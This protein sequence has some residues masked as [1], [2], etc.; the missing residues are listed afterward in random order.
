MK[1]IVILI[2]YIN[3]VSCSLS[4]KINV[5]FSIKNNSSKTISEIN[6]QT[7]FDSIQIKELK[8][9]ESFRK[10]ILYCDLSDINQ[11]ESRGFY[12]SFLRIDK[13]KPNTLGCGDI[14]SND[15]S[16]KKVDIS[17]IDNDIKTEIEGIECY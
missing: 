8:P 9:G 11:E 4:N 3:I 16:N 17:I 10:E 2:L 13:D 7:E 5:E 6:F 15:N 1:K 14:L 12:L